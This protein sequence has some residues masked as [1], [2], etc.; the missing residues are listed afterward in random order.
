MLAS[1]ALAAPAQTDIAVHLGAR[2]TLLG[3]GEQG[4]R[5]F[6]DGRLGIIERDPEYRVLMAAGVRSVLL[7]GPD[8]R[9]LR[10]VDT[11]IAPGAAGTFDNGYAGVN[12]IY[13]SGAD[14][15]LAFYHAEDQEG[16]PRLS[17]GVHGFYCSIGLAVS[18]DNGVTFLKN[19]PVLTSSQAKDL[20]GRPDQGVGAFCVTRDSSGK[21]LYLYYTSHS[22]VGGRGV[23]ICLARCPVEAAKEGFAWRKFHA[24]EFG[25]PGLGG[26]DTPVL[27]AAT[28]GGDGIMPHV[29]Y[30]AALRQYVMVF[31]VNA[32]PE[33]GTTPKRSGIYA[34]F[35]NDGLTWKE[36]DQQQLLVGYT[37]PAR[38]GT[39]VVWHPT[40]VLDADAANGTAKGWLYY[41]Y[42]ESWGHKPPHKPHYL[43]GAPVE[44]QSIL[45]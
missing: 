7:R 26:R 43:V 8:M 41:S 37:V 12:A 30:S 32:Y 9:H 2:T 17:N 24:G 23:Q 5:Y 4:L 27:S 13:Q 14:E 19:G 36:R 18:R 31:C 1:A 40:L 3:D 29:T 16:M 20:H 34:A 25:E 21:F 44:F 22:R 15:L 33:F 39:E 42:S 11:V 38:I 6:P 35:S 10:V 45:R 28:F